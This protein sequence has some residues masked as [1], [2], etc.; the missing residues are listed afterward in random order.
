MN[1]FRQAPF[2]R[3]LPAFILGIVLYRYE[4]VLVGNEL[5]LV[6]ILLLTLIAFHK[7][8]YRWQIVPGILFQIVFISFG[9]LVSQLNDDRKSDYYFERIN[10]ANGFVVE[11]QQ[12]PTLTKSGRRAL[13]KSTM[14]TGMEF[15]LVLAAKFISI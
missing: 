3:I 7:K 15:G 2:S 8:K 12:K 4:M 13:A 9:Y 6:S 1:I 14:F 10:G 5:L 11:I